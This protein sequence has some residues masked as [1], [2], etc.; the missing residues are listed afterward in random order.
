MAYNISVILLGET[1]AV[2]F[3][4]SS[5][6]ITGDEIKNWLVISA[7]IFPFTGLIPLSSLFCMC[8]KKVFITCILLP[9]I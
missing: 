5:S 1:K 9:V 8:S 3:L 7:H 4:D 2:I 6:K